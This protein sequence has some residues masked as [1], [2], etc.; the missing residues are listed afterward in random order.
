[1]LE[2]LD[3]VR[4]DPGRI[5]DIGAGT[6][7]DQRA[8]RV[9]YPRA[10]TIAVDS[11]LG[12][13]REAR[14]APGLVARWLGRAPWAVAADGACLPFAAGTFDLAW[15]NLALHWFDEPLA[16]F[17]EFARVLRPE[18]LLMFSA[19]GPDTLREVSIAGTEA[20]G[21]GVRAFPDLHDLGD[22]LI[23]AGFADPV[24]DAERITLS[25]ADADACLA[26][27]RAAALSAGARA[28]PTGLGGRARVHAVIASLERQRAAGRLAITFE[29]VYGHAWRGV[30][31]R[32]AE[33]HAIVQTDFGM[34]RVRRQD[35]ARN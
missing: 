20:G 9:R 2:R 8:L 12:M 10:A 24:M 25:Y 19:F 27:L 31:K 32:T 29:V 5:V 14:G 21:S 3:L 28:A 7:R 22:A 23:A 1:M 33:G 30:P 18:G 11:S 6:G 16:A 15:S 26:D 35:N 34:R 17:R 13:L 4:V